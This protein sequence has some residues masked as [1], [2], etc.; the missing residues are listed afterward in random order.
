LSILVNDVTIVDE[1]VTVYAVW[2]FSNIVVDA[3]YGDDGEVNVNVNLPDDEYYVTADDDRIIVTIPDADEDDVTVSVPGPGWSYDKEQDGDNVIVI[4]TPPPGYYLEECEDGDGNPIIVIY[5][6]VTFLPGAHGTF[7]G[8]VAEIRERVRRGTVLATGDVPTVNYSAGRPHVGW[9]PSNPVGHEVFGSITF[10][11]IFEGN[12]VVDAEYGDDGEVNVN[13][14]LPDDEYY[15]TVDDDRIIVTIPDADENDV[16]VNVPGPGWTY[17]KE[18]DGNDV[19]VIITPP[20]GYYLEECE[21]DDGNPIIVIYHYVTF[22]PGAHGTFAGSVA[23]IRERVRRSTVLATAQVPTVSANAGHTF[24]GWTPSNPVGHEVLGSITFIANFAHAGTP[25]QPPVHGPGP[26]LFGTPVRPRPIVEPPVEE[27]YG[28]H[29]RFIHGFPDGTMRAD[30]SITRAE[31]AMI[32]FRLLEDGNKFNSV[33]ARF[34]DVAH[35]SWYT[36]AINYLAHM[37]ILLGYPDGTFRP[38]AT[39]TRA[40]FTAIVVRFFGGGASGQ[41]NFIDVCAGH[42]EAAYIGAAAN[43]GWVVGHQDGTFRPDSAITR[44][45][46]V[47]IMNRILGREANPETIREHLGTNT[48]FTD[49]T[50]AHW[51]FFDIMEASIDHTYRIDQYGREIWISFTLPRIN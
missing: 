19:I 10:T 9:T 50:S 4:I 44:A 28:T 7:A 25:P 46:A 18:Q 2:R 48:I 24:S 17:E 33:P 20:P 37:N 32:I 34:S 45:E 35:G 42:W 27:A 49:L 21:D 23:E 22:L 39:I 11:A 1:N 47:V 29:L 36:Q 38:N 30:T 31:V 12:I 3:E 14:N 51:A 40:E 6:Y 13:V 26:G 43:R 8:S 16:T 5:H 41:N 15:V